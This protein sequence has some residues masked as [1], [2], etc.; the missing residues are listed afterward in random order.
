M[1]NFDKSS[2]KMLKRTHSDMG[3]LKADVFE[4]IGEWNSQEESDVVPERIN[5]RYQLRKKVFV[6]AFDVMLRPV[7]TMCKRNG[8]RCQRNISESSTRCRKTSQSVECKLP[9]FFK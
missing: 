5:N 6:D 7:F 9:N 3:K 1:L 8:K 4:F 2:L